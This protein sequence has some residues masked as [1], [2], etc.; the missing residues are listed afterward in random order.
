M[1]ST[2]SISWI[3][4]NF[5][6]SDDPATRINVRYEGKSKIDIFSP[7]APCMQN[8]DTGIEP[9]AYNVGTITR[10]NPTL[11]VPQ[12]SPRPYLPEQLFS[13]N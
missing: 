13:E 6:L 8:K 12:L 9:A 10:G 7:I 4:K 11:W 1:Y 5:K 2:S 3:V